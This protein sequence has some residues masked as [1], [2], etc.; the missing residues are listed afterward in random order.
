MESMKPDYNKQLITLTVITLSIVN[1]AVCALHVIENDISDIN[2]TIVFTY[3]FSEG[4]SKQQILE[5]KT[6]HETSHPFHLHYFCC[7]SKPRNTSVSQ[8]FI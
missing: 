6:L 2:V 8:T 7:T 4:M 3:C 1:Y 5:F